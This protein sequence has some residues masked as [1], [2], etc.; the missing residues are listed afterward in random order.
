[1]WFLRKRFLNFVNAFH[2]F[3]NISP[4]KRTG[5]FHLNKLEFPSQRMLCTQFGWN[6]S[7]GSGEED[8]N[9]KFTTTTT[10]TGNGQILIRKVHLSLRSWW[11]KNLAVRR[12]TLCTHCVLT[13]VVFQ[14]LYPLSTR[15]LWF[16]PRKKFW[17]ARNLMKG[18]TLRRLR[19]QSETFTCMSNVFIR[20]TSAAYLLL[21][22]GLP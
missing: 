4:W 12:K 15:K 22:L 20:Y 18:W 5:V 13:V 7:I 21:P 1:M 17:T 9:V 10:T 11:A 14:T 2:L 6:W 16:H 19:C 3:I 8:E